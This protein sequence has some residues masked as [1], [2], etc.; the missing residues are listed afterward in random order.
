MIALTLM[1][2][3]PQSYIRLDKNILA[4]CSDEEIDYRKRLARPNWEEGGSDADKLAK[5]VVNHIAPLL[6]RRQVGSSFY[7]VGREY[8]L[9]GVEKGLSWQH[10]GDVVDLRGCIEH[11]NTGH[12]R[13]Y[14]VPD[15]PPPPAPARA[16]KGGGKRTN[17][18][19]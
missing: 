12:I 5:A 7:T 16:K 17:K 11:F 19:R 3:E 15:S 8:L 4:Q 2:L 1:L 10:P 6:R 18:R 14:G 13:D 9:E